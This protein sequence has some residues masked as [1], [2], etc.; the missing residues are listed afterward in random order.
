VLP[1]VF[2]TGWR[3]PHAPSRIGITHSRMR[4]V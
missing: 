4:R 2:T 3:V 1:T